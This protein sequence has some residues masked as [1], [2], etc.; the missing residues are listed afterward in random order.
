MLALKFQTDIQCEQKHFISSA[1]THAHTRCVQIAT[2]GDRVRLA[3]EAVLMVVL[4]LCGHV[5]LK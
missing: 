5:T 2:L 3:D 4:V 1:D